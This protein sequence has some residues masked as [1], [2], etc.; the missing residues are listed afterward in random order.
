M[1][2]PAGNAAPRLRRWYVVVAFAVALTLV[3]GVAIAL[4]VANEPSAPKPPCK[5]G[6]P[7]RLAG[8]EEPVSFGKSWV[9]RD[10]GYSFE[11]TD[12]VLG[13]T[14]EDGTSV[15]LGAHGTHVDA[16]LWVAGARDRD[17]SVEQL[18]AQRKDALAQRVL[19]LTEANDS[20]TR[21]MAPG[22][23]FVRGKGAAYTGT[24]DSGSG[25][26]APADVIIMG[27]GDKGVNVVL[28]L[29]ITGEGLS[30]KDITS[31]REFIALIPVDTLQFA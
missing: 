1:P 22:L 27:A 8:D 7:C 30:S 11:Y 2:R 13:I 17:S 21:L 31:I 12:R 10:L 20:P 9:S 18:V 29:L 15:K 6:E 5:P 28:S 14:G 23:G 25:P 3:A 19:G 24:L 16:E 4:L 26:T